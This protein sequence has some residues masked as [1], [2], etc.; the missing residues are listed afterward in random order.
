MADFHGQA[1]KARYL[2]GE[3][4]KV[5]SVHGQGVKEVVDVHGQMVVV[6]KAGALPQTRSQTIH[7]ARMAPSQASF[8]MNSQM[9]EQS[10]SSDGFESEFSG[11]RESLVLCARL[12]V[13]N[14]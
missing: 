10:N 8:S 9:D 1:E 13:D 6:V 7:W 5:V 11:V 14:T 4:E 3:E 2:H 12:S